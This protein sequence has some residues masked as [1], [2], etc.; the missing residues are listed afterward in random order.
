MQIGVVPDCC[1][2][3]RGRQGGTEQ[4]KQGKKPMSTQSAL[5][6]AAADLRSVISSARHA[7]ALL[8]VT[9]AIIEERHPLSITVIHLHR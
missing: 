4:A 8:A 6:S 3:I 5:S 1:E 9:S 2:R 7:A